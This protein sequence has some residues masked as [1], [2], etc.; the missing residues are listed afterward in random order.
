MWG[1][2]PEGGAAIYGHILPCGKGIF[3]TEDSLTDDVNDFTIIPLIIQ[4]E[5]VSALMRKQASR[6]KAHFTG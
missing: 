3:I 6:M 4:E 5:D 2:L 1:H